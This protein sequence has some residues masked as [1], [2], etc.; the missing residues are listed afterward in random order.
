MVARL[1]ECIFPDSN[2]P[3]EYC[4]VRSP[5]KVVLLKKKK[6]KPP[7][8]PQV[9]TYSS[10]PVQVCKEKGLVSRQHVR[11]QPCGRAR[12]PPARL[13][14]QPDR[15]AVTATPCA[16]DLGVSEWISACLCTIPFF[17]SCP[18]SSCTLLV[19]GWVPGARNLPPFCGFV[20]IGAA[21]SVLLCLGSHMSP[22]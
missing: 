16:G 4:F 22:P 3:G 7:P 9:W 11:K 19:P 21:G 14:P 10:C 1:S 5:K 18:A 2:W 15:W 13:C 12:A 6:K 20:C 8:R 17:C